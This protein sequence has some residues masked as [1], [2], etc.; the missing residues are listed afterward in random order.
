MKVFQELPQ[1]RV[2]AGLV[3]GLV[4]LGTPAGE[5]PLVKFPM[6]MNWDISLPRPSWTVK[7]HPTHASAS[8][9]GIRHRFAPHPLPFKFYFTITP[10]NQT[11]IRWNISG[12][13]TRMNTTRTKWKAATTAGLA[14]L[15]A[16]REMRALMAPG[17]VPK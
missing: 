4:E 7:S 3:Y 9:L 15:S 6:K 10:G 11:R 13:V 8:I 14:S 5:D 16:A 17:L 1:D 12:A 2:L